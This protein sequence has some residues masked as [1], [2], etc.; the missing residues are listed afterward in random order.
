[1]DSHPKLTISR[2]EALSTDLQMKDDLDLIYVVLV[3]MG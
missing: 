1:M 2:L 3:Y